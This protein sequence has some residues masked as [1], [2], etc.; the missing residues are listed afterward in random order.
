[1]TFGG[2]GF[3]TVEVPSVT[4]TVT[5]T[6]ILDRALIVGA[7]TEQVTVQADVEAI[8]TANATVGAV[9]GG[10]T[11]TDLPL[12]TRN[13]QNLIGL[14][15]GAAA[16]VPNASSIG[17]ATTIT[18]V[19]GADTSE[20]NFQMDGVAVGNYLSFGTGAE[21]GFYGAQ[22]IP[23][24]DSIAEFKIQTSTYDAGYGRDPGANVNVVTKSGTNDFHGTA[25]EFFRNTVLN[26]NDFFRKLTGG[27]RLVLNQNQYGGVIGGPIKKNKLFFFVSYQETAQKNGVNAAG[28][29]RSWRRYSTVHLPPIP[30]GSRGTCPANWTVL[31]QCDAAAQAFVPALGAAI[32]PANFPSNAFDKVTVAGSIQVACNGSNI[33]PV[34]VNILQLKLPNGNYFVPGSGVSP[35]LPYPLQTFSDPARCMRSIR[36]WATGI[37]SSTR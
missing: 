27:S 12:T 35:S 15:P 9:I 31:T 24:P 36:V 7:Q 37:M 23:N 8:Q 4:V 28:G 6:G 1:M 17:K 33:N 18:A 2:V 19:N 26:A 29:K 10:E 30:A 16:A 25:F 3:R 20:N 14:S 5:E 32:C 22:P 34:A 11:V 21:G 13:Y